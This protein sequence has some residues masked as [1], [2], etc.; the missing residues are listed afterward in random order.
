MG[1]NF[2]KEDRTLLTHHVIY[3]YDGIVEV[4]AAA[5]ERLELST[6]Y[7]PLN[8]PLFSRWARGI[9]DLVG[10]L[11][12]LGPSKQDMVNLWFI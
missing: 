2:Y 6:A 7:A 12:T 1:R 11:K 10:W 4:R 9:W 5:W 3:I 8:F